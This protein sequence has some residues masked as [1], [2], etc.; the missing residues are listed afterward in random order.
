MENTD[1]TDNE[2]KLQRRKSSQR[3]VSFADSH[4]N[5]INNTLPTENHIIQQDTIFNQ[6]PQYLTNIQELTD[7]NYIYWI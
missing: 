7:G 1:N 6:K 3:P 4:I 5:I 2:L